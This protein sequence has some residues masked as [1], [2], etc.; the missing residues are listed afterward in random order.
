MKCTRTNAGATL[1]VCAVAFA[2]IAGCQRERTPQP[3]A[4]FIDKPAPS[5]PAPASALTPGDPSVP[6]HGTP[7]APATSG[8][9][10]HPNTE[11]TKAERDKALPLE[12]QVNNYNSDAFAKRGD[13]K[14]P[15]DPAPGSSP[16]K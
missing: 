9:D 7:A 14:I 6:P 2:G 15:R 12:G 16:P 3:A 10:A 1:I 5:T 8:T 4:A 11:L 13:E